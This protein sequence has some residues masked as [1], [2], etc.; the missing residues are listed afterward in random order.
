MWKQKRQ[1]SK[2]LWKV[3]CTVCLKFPVVSEQNGY[4]IKYYVIFPQQAVP[5]FQLGIIAQLYVYSLNVKKFV[6]LPKVFAL[7]FS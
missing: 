4:N 7:L 5:V 6:K 1:E 2:F 3:N